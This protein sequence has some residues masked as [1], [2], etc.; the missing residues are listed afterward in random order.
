MR[1][2]AREIVVRVPKTWEMRQLQDK[3]SKEFYILKTY[4]R[5]RLILAILIDLVVILPA[6][7]MYGRVLTNNWPALALLA[8]LC[9]VLNLGMDDLLIRQ[10]NIIIE[11][12]A[13]NITDKWKSGS[14]E[15]LTKMLED[16]VVK[17][18]SEKQITDYIL[19]NMSMDANDYIC[20]ALVFERE[21]K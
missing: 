17:D 7:Q 11:E 14:F 15:K 21:V 1:Q 8:G 18:M 19:Y 4:K 3:A 12:N 6:F 2:K 16:Y 5:T 20:Y 10:C 9:F 13:L